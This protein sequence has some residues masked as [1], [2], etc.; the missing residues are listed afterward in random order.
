MPHQPQDRVKINDVE[1]DFIALKLYVDQQWHPIEARQMQ[2]LKLLLKHHGSA[3]S[4]HQIMDELWQDTVV[5]DNSVSQA[6]TQLRRSL[7]DDIGTPRFIRTVPRIGYQLIADIQTLLPT[8]PAMHNSASMATANLPLKSRHTAI[9]ATTSA[10]VAIVL[11]LLAIQ[12]FKPNLTVPI[13]QYESRLTSV[14]GPER[15]LRYSTNGRYLA[16]SQS[17]D[18]RRHM[19]LVVYDDNNHAIHSIKSTGYSELAPE[20]SSDGRWLI[21][22]RQDPI[23]C[24]IR[25]MAVANP[26]ETW[27][28]SPDFHLSDCQPGYARQ[29]MHW[30]E[31]QTIYL[32]GWQDDHPIL[33]KITLTTEGLPKVI[34]KERIGEFKPLLMDIDK[35]S[36]QMLMVER[37]GPW[38]Q[39]KSVNLTNLETRL[40]NRSKQ[41]YAGL[42]WHNSGKNFWL[43]NQT[44]RLMWLNGASKLVHFPMGVIPDLDVNPVTGQL[45]HAEGLVQVNLYSINVNNQT[46][47]RRLSSSARTDI[48]PAL[49][50]D[51]QQTAFVSYQSR[52]KDGLKHVEVWLK[53]QHKK[54]ASLLTNLPE[55][56]QPVYLL[57]SPNGEN[58][59]LGDSEHKL[60][61]INTYS[62]HMVPIV[63]DYQKIN[64]VNWSPDGKHISFRARLGQK[65]QHWQYDLQ[66]ATTQ[67]IDVPQTTVQITQ[68]NPSYHDYSRRIANHLIKALGDEIPTDNLI[69]SF[70][71][72]RPAIIEQGIY[73]VIHLGHQ[74]KLY[75]YRFDNQSNQYVS[76]IGIHQQDI[77]VQLN[78][79]AAQ[80]GT[81]L[82]YSKVEE[83]ETDI[84][85]QRPLKNVN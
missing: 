26:V 21:Y 74:L 83:I 17:S 19:D 60:Y 47:R 66:L 3:V 41:D 62:K 48:L 79:T 9:I 23:S 38:Y 68:L 29:K 67:L 57:W 52:S 51:G 85:V 80:N 76:D 16:F 72:Y 42:K 71:L 32:T 64:A 8:T 2:L 84:V 45:A 73:Y 50:H 77:N 69:P 1:V 54:A 36:G 10:I 40:I 58:L 39:L 61:L 28:L 55:Q 37:L 33:S 6:V 12:W 18:N 24:D 46:H 65:Q 13:Y 4:R 20:W 30:L 75:F 53:H 35:N 34:K 81:Q 78:L 11:T 22:Y 7:H 44:L 5:S 25:I 15:F 82:V 43:G 31:P 70:S 49:S 27:R 14:P 63:N 59:L 56:T